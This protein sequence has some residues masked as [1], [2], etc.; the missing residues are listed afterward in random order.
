VAYSILRL[1]QELSP[2][3]APENSTPTANTFT[4]ASVIPI[5]TSLLNITHRHV[6]VSSSYLPTDPL[7]DGTK[8]GFAER[9]CSK[10]L[11]AKLHWQ[12]DGTRCYEADGS[13]RTADEEIDSCAL[14]AAFPASSRCY[15]R[16][17]L[18]WER[19]EGSLIAK[20]L[21]STTQQSRYERAKI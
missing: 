18:I 1:P 16:F 9:K 13:L 12:M 15:S 3:T 21:C 5:I 11:T 19:K 10:R 7:A 6:C 2:D 8:F 4:E 17:S 14:T 20:G